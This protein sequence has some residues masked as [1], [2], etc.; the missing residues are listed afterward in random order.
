MASR[1]AAEASC[2]CHRHVECP[3][4]ELSN[5]FAW[6]PRILQCARKPLAS[7]DEAI[8]AARAVDAGEEERSKPQ[9][10]IPPPFR[11]A[12][13]Q[14]LARQDPPM[15]SLQKRAARHGGG[16]H[17]PAGGDAIGHSQ[18]RAPPPPVSRLCYMVNFL[19]RVNVGFA[20]LAMNEDLGFSPSVFGAGAG[21][22]FIGYIL[23]EVPSN[24][25]LQ[26][27][28]ARIWIARIMISWGDHRL[29]MAFV[30]G[31]DELLRRALPARR[32]RSRL[33]PRHHPLSDLLVPGARAGAHRRRCSWRR[34]RSPP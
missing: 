11:D 22:F 26:R 8:E 34:S 17:E 15:A 29:A 28:G 6:R 30:S 3:P 20:A 10:S 12:T 5:Q 23:F 2:Q 19:D 21:I 13:W 16:R 7:G 25:A 4:R 14:C 27:F 9:A 1:M 33:L 18:G 32:G 31:D 24:L